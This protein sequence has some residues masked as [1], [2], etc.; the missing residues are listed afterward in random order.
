MPTSIHSVRVFIKSRRNPLRYLL[1]LLY[2]IQ[3]TKYKKSKSKNEINLY[4]IACRVK[5]TLG[6]AGSSGE[7]T[8]YTGLI[9]V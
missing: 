8:R 4:A 5:P 7:T 3:N 9:N 6:S 1:I 2:C